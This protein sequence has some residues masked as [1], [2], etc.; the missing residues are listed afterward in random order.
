ML[1][2]LVT[3]CT[4]STSNG[5]LNNLKSYTVPSGALKV[6][7]KSSELKFSKFLLLRQQFL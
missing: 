2:K 7:K 6:N 4:V 3:A 1:P 5:L